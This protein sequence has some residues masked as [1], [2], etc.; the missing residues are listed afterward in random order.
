[1]QDRESES[2]NKSSQLDEDMSNIISHFSDYNLPNRRAFNSLVYSEQLQ[3]KQE[4]K[5]KEIVKVR[6]GLVSFGLPKELVSSS[7]STA[8]INMMMLVVLLIREAT[9]LI[10][11]YLSD[12]FDLNKGVEGCTL[13]CKEYS[14]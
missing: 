2:I 3:G 1:M 14:P 6:D 11:Y 10:C 13:P 9:Y 7:L 4:R 8:E 5:K 12:C